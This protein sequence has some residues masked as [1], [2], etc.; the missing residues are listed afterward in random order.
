MTH[1]AP[2]NARLA[3][4]PEICR[5][6]DTGRW[7]IPCG[8]RSLY[9]HA[10]RTLFASLLLV[11]ACGGH[12]KQPATGNAAGG[13]AGPS[14]RSIDWANRTYNNSDA[15]AVTVKDGEAMF[16]I[17]PEMPD[18]RGWFNVSAPSYGDVDGDGV[19]DAVI[20]TT[21]NGGGTGN[22]TTG[23]VYTM[24][25]GAPEP[26]KLGEIP[27]GDRGDGGLDGI[28]IEGGK[29]RVE[30]NLSTEDDGTC[31]PS[32][33]VREVWHWDGHAFVED[34]AARQTVANPN[35]QPD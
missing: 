33:L 7:A 28:A 13:A 21:Y 1:G 27:G 25:A 16:D 34:E 23:E 6:S 24:R 30:R 32:K 10:M 5:Q 3:T 29:L 14:I 18:V 9:E 22:F 8:P 15:G 35:Y 4:G 12:T 26:V 17:D 19:E 20:I 2:A 11:A 31:C